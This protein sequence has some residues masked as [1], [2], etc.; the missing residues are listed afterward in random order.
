MRKTGW[1]VAVAVIVA[2]VM[3]AG[4]MTDLRGRPAPDEGNA[5]AVAPNAGGP[6]PGD[7]CTVYLR[8]DATGA[9]YHD[10][11][12]AVGNLVSRHGSVVRTDGSWFVLSHDGREDWIP[13]TSIALIEVSAGREGEASR[14]EAREGNEDDQGEA[15]DDRRGLD[16]R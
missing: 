6:R 7:R 4:W 13:R 12:A 3:L 11:V 10:R 9:V 5:P 8:G 1:G 16:L 15:D 2:A 14:E